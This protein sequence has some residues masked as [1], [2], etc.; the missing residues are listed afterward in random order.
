VKTKF[1]PALSLFV[2]APLVAE[3]LLG[4]LPMSMIA[5]LPIMAAMY[6]SAALLIRETAR[7]SG[8]AGGRSPCSGSLTA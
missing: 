6:G 8:R 5:I 3:Y 1:A 2:I 7:R 4:S